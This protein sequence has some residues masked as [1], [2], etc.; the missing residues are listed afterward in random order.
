MK[1]DKMQAL[2]SIIEAKVMMR[3]KILTIIAHDHVNTL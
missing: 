1:E 3:I 2:T